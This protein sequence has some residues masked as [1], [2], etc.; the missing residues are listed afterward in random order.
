MKFCIGINLLVTSVRIPTLE[1]LLHC[2]KLKHNLII[3][4]SGSSYIKDGTKN[5]ISH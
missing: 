2:I 1:H 5:K 3:F 4:K